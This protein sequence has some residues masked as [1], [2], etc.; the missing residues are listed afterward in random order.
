MNDMFDVHQSEWEAEC[1]LNIFCLSF[2]F[3]YSVPETYQKKC[4]KL[5]FFFISPIQ[6]RV[7]YLYLA[8]LIR[9]QVMPL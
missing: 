9:I 3:K 2:N 6:Y 7:M 1:A 4:A 8:D 5:I